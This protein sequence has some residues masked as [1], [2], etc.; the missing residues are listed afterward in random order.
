MAPASPPGDAR[1]VRSCL[2]LP[3]LLGAWSSAGAQALPAEVEPHS[4]GARAPGD[5]RPRIGLALGGGG[6]RGIAHISVLR[7]LEELHVP[8]D[9]IAGTSMG[10]LV[11]GLYASGM[12][13]GELEQLVIETDWKRMFDDSLERPERSFRRKQDDR[14]GLAT[15]GVG[16]RGGEIKLA[17]GLLQGERVLALFERSTLRVSAI[18]DF[19]RLPIPYRAVATDLNTGG[20]VVLEKGSLAMAMRASM[21]LPGIFVP[22]EV[23]GRVLLD[24][25]LANQ[26]PIDVVRAMGADIV[27]AV[28]VGTPLVELGG[29]ASLFEIVYQISGMMTTGNTRQQLDTLGPR[30]VLILPELGSDV[31][32]GDFDKAR[33]ALAIGASA[34]AARREQ[35]ARLSLPAGRYGQVLAQRP[36]VPA[37]APVVDFVRLDNQTDYADELL[38][39]YLPVPTGVPLDT[40]RMEKSL[41]RTYSLT[42]L[43]SVTY[44]VVEE[45]G[46]TGVILRAGRAA[47]PNYL[48]L[49]LVVHSDFESA[50]EANLRVAVLTAPLSRYGAKAGCREI[51]SEPGLKGILPSARRGQPELAVREPWSY[52][53]PNI[54][55]F[56]VEG[57]NIATYDVSLNALELKAGHEFG[58][59]GALFVGVRRS[60]GRARVEIGNPGWRNSTSTRARCSQTSLSTGSTACISHVTGTT[61]GSAI[62]RPATG[63]AAT[64]NSSRS[65]STCSG[66]Q[67]RQA[68]RAASGRL[69]RDRVGR[70]ARS[71]PL[72]AGGRRDRLVGFRLNELTGQHYALLLAGYS[73]QL[74]ELLGRAAQIGATLE[75][76]NA[77]ERRQDMSFDDGILNASIYVGFDSRVGPMFSASVR[78]E[79]GHGLLF[80]EIGRAFRTPPPL[81][82]R[83]LRAATSPRTAHFMI[84]P[85]SIRI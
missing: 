63:W 82:V 72:P 76:G 46:R 47:G 80:L 67:F 73:Y 4:C 48:Q 7:T 16:F 22:V 41:L 36:V 62:R 85:T 84:L 23:D 74:A 1:R 34:A 11:G 59:L 61:P 45:N 40:E 2:L 39:A 29:D 66:P 64:A 25:G 65:M 44:E 35:L 21:S 10:A 68:F 58:N 28:D 43:A 17:P 70:T 51:G 13:V 14:D 24:G 53:N 83:Q 60:T 31:T 18:D 12:S 27:I 75:Y 20:A 52:F 42:T 38:L 56:D 5:T 71:G 81:S 30:D 49:G 32:T 77:W 55:V 69:S 54:H 33:E 37:Q 78:R 9:C 8:V 57:S 15:L 79:A 26:V 6:A 3:L 50:F 19:D